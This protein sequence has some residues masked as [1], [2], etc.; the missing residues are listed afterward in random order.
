MRFILCDPPALGCK[1]KRFWNHEGFIPGSE[2][3]YQ[4]SLVFLYLQSGTV[5]QLL[6]IIAESIKSENVLESEASNKC[7]S[8]PFLLHEQGSCGRVAASSTLHLQYHFEQL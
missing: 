1:G 8:F 2:S 5:T 4:L 7:D 6:H 3:I